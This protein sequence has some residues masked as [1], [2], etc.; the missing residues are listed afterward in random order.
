MA[1]AARKELQRLRIDERQLSL[2]R[3]AVH[4]DPRVRIEVIEALPLI[5]SIDTRQ[6][7]LWFSHD[8]DPKVRRA[9]LSLLATSG[10]PELQRRVR[11]AAASDSDPRVREQSRAAVVRAP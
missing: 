1:D 5:A 2:A 9:A 4:S 3:S 6:W 8:R 11:Q 10:D 7:L